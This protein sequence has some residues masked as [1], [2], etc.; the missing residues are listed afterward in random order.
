MKKSLLIIAVVGAIVLSLGVSSQAF[1]QNPDP[2]FPVE[3]RRGNRSAGTNGVGIPVEMNINLDG[4]LKNLLHGYLAEAIGV[5]PSVLADGNF[6]AIALAEGYDLTEIRAIVLEAHSAALDQALVDILVT[7]EEYD[8]LSVRGFITRADG[9]HSGMEVGMGP[10]MG[11]GTG[12]C[13]EDG[14]PLF[15]GTSQSKGYRGGK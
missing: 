8:W 3:G 14:T 11:N 2:S 4:D 9:N 10:G 12:T 13:L 15:D 7:Q 1:A 5:D 6:E